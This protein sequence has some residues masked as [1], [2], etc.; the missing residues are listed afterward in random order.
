MLK[1]HLDRTKTNPE[2]IW[3]FLRILTVGKLGKLGK[4]NVNQSQ[5]QCVTT[6]SHKCNKGRV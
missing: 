4:F 2:T 6:M 3:C 5:S 1:V